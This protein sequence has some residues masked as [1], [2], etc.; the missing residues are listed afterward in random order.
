M[1]RDAAP[2]GDE[3]DENVFG[4]I[5]FDQLLPPLNNSRVVAAQGLL[6]VLALVTKNGLI[7]HQ[8]EAFGPIGLRII[9]V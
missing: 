9:E 5:D 8:E 3:E 4:C 2:P 7:A 6:H 1:E